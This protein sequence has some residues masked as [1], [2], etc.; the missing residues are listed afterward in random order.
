MWEEE[1]LE[2]QGSE[3]RSKGLRMGDDPNSFLFC[4]FGGTSLNTIGGSASFA[5]QSVNWHFDHTTAAPGSKTDF[6]SIAL[7]E[8][9]HG[10]GLATASGRP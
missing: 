4:G 8:V 10:L 3:E 7:H 6:Y 5:T 1:I 2:A 9:A